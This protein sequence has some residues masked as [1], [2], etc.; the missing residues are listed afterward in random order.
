MMIAIWTNNLSVANR[1]IDSAHRDIISMI[2]GFGY[3]IKNR[4][5]AALTE[6]FGFFEDSLYA[7][8]E[9]EEKIAA[10]IKVDFGQHKLAHQNLLNDFHCMK[11]SLAGKNGEW[12][13]DEAEAVV[14]S[15]GKR[16]IQHIKDDGKQMKVV[17]G[18]HYYDFQPD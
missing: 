3:L 15:W 13:I 6:T 9:I 2:N 17:L 14:R 7:Y 18:T 11:N 1:A 5:D 8:F 4:D 16:F 10:A 12:S